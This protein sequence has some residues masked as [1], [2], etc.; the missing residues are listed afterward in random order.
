LEGGSAKLS[1]NASIASL[2][3]KKEWVSLFVWGGG[4]NVPQRPGTGGQGDP[5]AVSLFPECL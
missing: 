5:T 1:K 4:G 2:E 3:P